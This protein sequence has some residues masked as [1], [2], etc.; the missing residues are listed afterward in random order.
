MWGKKARV[1]VSDSF[2]TAQSCILLLRRGCLCVYVFLFCVDVR[3]LGLDCELRTGVLGQIPRRTI[4]TR[5]Y[6]LLARTRS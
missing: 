4:R 3:C 6:I 5:V 1:S 2:K